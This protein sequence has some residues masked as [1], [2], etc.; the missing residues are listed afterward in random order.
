MK[1]DYLLFRRGFLLTNLKEVKFKSKLANKIVNDWDKNV[2]GNYTIYSD[3]INSKS[4]YKYRDVEVFVMGLV[5]NPFNNDRNIENITKEL[6]HRLSKSVDK[7]LDYLDELSGRFIVVTSK[8]DKTEVY[9]DACATR[10]VFYNKYG[11]STVIASHSAII[12]ELLNIEPSKYSVEM[13]NHPTYSGVRYLPGLLS[14]YDDVLPLTPNTKYTIETKKVER[15][16][17]RR[18]LKNAGK[19]SLNRKIN[20]IIDLMIRQAENITA[21]DKVSISLTAGIDSR[22]TYAIFEQTKGDIEYFTHISENNPEA[23]EEDISIAKQLAKDVGKP[24]HIYKYNTNKDQEGYKEF[25]VIWQKNIGMYRGSVL[26]NKMYADTFPQDRIHVR[27]NLAE[28]GRV[29]Y[30]RYSHE[31]NAKELARLYTKTDFHKNEDV[32][33]LFEEFMDVTGFEKKN[34]YNFEYHDL[35]Y[36]E[37]RMALWH[38]WLLLEG[39]MSHETFIL[40]NNRKLLENI[41]EIPKEIREKSKLFIRIIKKIAPSALKYPVNGKLIGEEQHD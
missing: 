14:P 38:S 33:K 40:F 23:F 29:Y 37:H 21:M 31:L 30:K 8:N 11:D 10:T 26:M 22:L 35:F 15:Y 25:R 39:D 18:P 3:K 4:Q 28:I 16:Y 13:L 1:Y 27:S 41:L 24:H 36:W 6:A 20:N 2:F 19:W 17:P 7:F 32:I 5:F 34:L 9:H 12:G